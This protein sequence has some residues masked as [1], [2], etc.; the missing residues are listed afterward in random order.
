MSSVQRG[1]VGAQLCLA[2][3]ILIGTGCGVDPV[4]RRYRAERD[5]WRASRLE[6]E[7]RI[8][9][10]TPVTREEADRVLDAYRGLMA[11]NPV[12]NGVADTSMTHGI[13]R[14]RARAG[15]GMVRMNGLKGDTTEVRKIL[16]KGRSECPWDLN[17]T[18][19]LTLQLVDYQRG[20]GNP[21]AAVRLLHEMASGLPARVHGRPVVPVQEAPIRAADILV[22][23]GDPNAAMSALVDAE[24]Y[25]R[26]VIAA[27]PSD[28]ASAF[29]LVELGTVAAR[30]G[31]YDDAAARIDEA[32]K[33]TVADEL[34]PKILY[35][36]G[37]LQQ[38]GRHDPAAASAVFGE[39]IEK[40]PQD[41]FASEAMLRQGQCA[42]D[43]GKADEAIAVLSMVEQAYPRDRVMIPRA[44]VMAARILGRT[45]RWTEALS[46]YRAID[47]DYPSSIE[48]LQA[49]LEI[50]LHYREAGESDAAQTTL[51]AALERYDGIV[52]R[53][54]GSP[55]ARAADE[56]SVRVLFALERWGDAAEK[57]LSFK[58][59]YPNNPRNPL[60]LL[61]AAQV[62]QDHLNNPQR[63]VE[64][65]QDVA[66]SYPRSP[67]AAKALEDAQRIRGR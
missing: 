60:A 26:E 30:R 25:Y 39:L 41:P 33:L 13:A 3:L 15:L 20:V 36:L 40:Y 4:G 63:A 49:P 38:E 53:S 5:F 65:L 16:E 61:D 55:L 35:L 23:G 46:R 12:P 62:Y 47:A 56:T 9:R 2:G 10:D 19:G 59:A 58:M 17:I 1:I 50:A 28:A 52:K 32:R 54:P 37:V 51:R 48:A 27:A 8:Q 64:I 29:A 14:I 45:G 22:E 11:R 18:L 21:E 67:L 43:Q 6:S 42:A 44:R 24:A 57:L 7:L 34:Q 66:A 31:R